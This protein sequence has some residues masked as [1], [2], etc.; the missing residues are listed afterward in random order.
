[1]Q[2]QS[3]WMPE[4]V[5]IAQQPQQQS[6]QQWS[7]DG[8]ETD[9][10]DDPYALPNPLLDNSHDQQLSQSCEPVP[11]PAHHFQPSP[12][13]FELTAKG[14]QDDKTAL[15]GAEVPQADGY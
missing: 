2:P 11:P 9:K 8:G 7:H 1:M 4:T 5:A 13:T 6:L 14:A 12:D 15:I 10:H 3:V